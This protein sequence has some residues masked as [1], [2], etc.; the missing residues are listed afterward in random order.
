MMKS[1][2]IIGKSALGGA[3][4]CSY[5][6]VSAFGAQSVRT[7]A[8][9]KAKKDDKKTAAKEKDATPKDT[10]KK[11]ANAQKKKKVVNEH[12]AHID[13]IYHFLHTSEDARRYETEPLF[14]SCRA[15]N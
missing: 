11:P 4:R 9:V 10:K 5:P 6:A 14:L 2:L 13:A 7:F 15:L 12:Q 8:Q 1:V 3:Q